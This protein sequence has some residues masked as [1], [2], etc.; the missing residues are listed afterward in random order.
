MSTS[1]QE[2]ISV[3]SARRPPTCEIVTIGSELLLGQIVDTN[4][5]YL[6]QEL[7]REGVTISF[8]TAV[9][10][11]LNQIDE[12][13]RC[14]VDRCDLVITTGGLGP[15]L[16]DLTREA[17]ARAAGVTLEFRQDLMDE[18]EELFRRVGY[19]MP[20]N[21]RRQAFVPEGSLAISNPVGTAPAF[22]KEISGTPVICL[23]GVPR[24]L[25]HLLKHNVVPWLRQ[26]YGLADH[27]LTYRVLKTVGIGESKVD[28]L[29]GDYIRP[30]SNPEVGLLASMGEVKIRIAARAKDA[31][32]AEAMI[33]PVEEDI[34]SRLGNRI[35]GRD[36]DDTLEEVIDSLLANQGLTLAVVETFS[37]GAAAQ[38]L[39]R[40]PTSRLKDSRVIPDKKRAIKW[41]GLDGDRP[42]N[43]ETAL[44]MAHKVKEVARA[45]MG[46]AILGFPLKAEK[47]YTLEGHVAVTG[48]GIEKVFSWEMGGDLFTLEQRG[49]IIGLN[50]LR[51]ALI[52]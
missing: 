39:H 34:L 32:E 37:G 26:R 3:N 16:D 28:R 45:G 38:R 51:L 21:N 1:K 24:E 17:V 10:D 48:E 35:Y 27:R 9:G 7:S 47:A 5:S 23:P 14:A 42:I 8:R 11:Y 20:G 36:D 2:P 31:R 33:R 43:S 41:L 49:A 29:I 12:V 13:I 4:T 50:T 46:L 44:A 52:E 25:K 6:A 22:I 15:T 30:G 19:Q 40:L 18:I